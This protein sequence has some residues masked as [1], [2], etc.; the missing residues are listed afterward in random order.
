MSSSARGLG[1]LRSR[2]GRRH[3]GPCTAEAEKLW[4]CQYLSNWDIAIE[5]LRTKG[6]NVE[7]EIDVVYR[8]TRSDCF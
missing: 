1:C 4:S 7:A 8:D 3:D 5:R 2:A 6:R